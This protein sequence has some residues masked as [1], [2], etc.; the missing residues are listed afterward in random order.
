MRLI[1]NKRSAVKNLSRINPESVSDSGNRPTEIAKPDSS[2]EQ[3]A[4]NK[5]GLLETIKVKIRGAA[6][7]T[8]FVANINYKMRKASAPK[9]ILLTAAKPNTT[10]I[11]QH[12]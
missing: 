6:T 10:A 7:A 5:A 2:I 11:L 4:Y 12:K 9:F 3:S 8:D 1:F